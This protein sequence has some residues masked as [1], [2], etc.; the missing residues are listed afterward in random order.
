MLIMAPLCAVCL[1]PALSMLCRSALAGVVF[2]IAIPGLLLLVGNIIATAWY[3]FV[4]TDAVHAFISTF[5]WRGVSI[6]CAAGAIA[7]WVLFVR[8]EAIEG[9]R[10]AAVATLAARRLVAGCGAQGARDVDRTRPQGTAPSADDLRGRRLVHP[11][12]RGAVDALACES[13]ILGSAVRGGR[14]AVWRPAV[15]PDWLGSKR[16]GTAAGNAGLAAA[17]ADRGANTVGCQGR[18]DPVAGARAGRRRAHARQ[19]SLFLPGGTRGMASPPREGDAR[20]GGPVDELQ[21]LRFEPELQRRAGHGQQHPGRHRR[22][23][24]RDRHPWLS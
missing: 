4:P 20:G 5:V 15:G 21:P 3:G 2:T 16:R 22:M 19:L 7:T 10:R 17:A 18:H 9:A 14:R 8:L 13:R 6:A 11:G 23:G 1:A 12:V 24:V